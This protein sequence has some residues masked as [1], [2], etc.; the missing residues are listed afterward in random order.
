MGKK[1]KRPPV[2][3]RPEGQSGSPPPSRGAESGP[4][5]PAALK[6]WPPR[7]DEFLASHLAWWAQLDQEQPVYWLAEE[8]VQ[9]LCRSG[10]TP[11]PRP[12]KR[13][14]GITQEEAA[15]ERDFRV[16][17]QGL[18]ISSVGFWQGKPVS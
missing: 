6:P 10:S 9:A 17:C 11:G 4:E 2:R 13:P 16:C 3:S 1:R 18:L 8:V 14:A 12:R 7:W 5:A 15:A